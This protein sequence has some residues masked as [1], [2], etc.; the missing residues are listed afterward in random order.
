MI[1]VKMNA[2]YQPHAITIAGTSSGVANAPTFV[3]ALK[4]PVAS[5]RSFFGNHSATVLIEAGK[6]PASPSPSRN[7]TTIK[8]ITDAE[9][10]KVHGAAPNIELKALK[11]A[12]TAATIGATIGDVNSPIP[13]AHA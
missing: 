9:R 6:L 4:M 12:T 13:G 10:V 11:A 7:L 8:P 3:P 5:A 1:P 2:S